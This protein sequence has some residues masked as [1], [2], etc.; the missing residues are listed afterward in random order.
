MEYNFSQH[1]TKEDYVAFLMNH[2]KM[3]IMRPFNLGLFVVGLGYLL[4]APIITGSG[5]YTFTVIGLAL[6]GVMVL[7]VFFARYN[8]GKRYDKNQEMFDMTYR[9]TEEGFSYV[10]GTQ[11]VEKKWFD[12]YS[13]SETE[14]YLYIFA[15]KDS[16]SVLVKRDIPSDAVDF[17]RSKLVA[18][19]NPKRVKVFGVE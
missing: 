9:A 12:F 17:I 5:D 19:V 18:H 2:L 8:A 3:N 11:A 14:E 7:S 4:S 1:V 16:G 10:V 6:I 13:A 15:S